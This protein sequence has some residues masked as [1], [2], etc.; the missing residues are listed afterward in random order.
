MKRPKPAASEGGHHRMNRRDFLKTGVTATAGLA[1]AAGSAGQLFSAPSRSPNLLVI[2]TDQQSA[3]TLGAYGGAVIGTPNI[4]RIGREGATLTNFF[5]NCAICTPSRGC[6]Q[7][8][9]YPHAN[10]AVHNNFAL[11]EDE[12]TLGHVMKRNG[13]DTGYIGKWHLAGKEK[14]H[15]HPNWNCWLPREYSMGY[16]DCRYMFEMWHGKMISGGTQNPRMDDLHWIGDD[17]MTKTLDLERSV[18]DENS[19]TTD[20]L[21]DRAMDFVN[22]PRENPFCLFLS[23]PDPHNPFHGRSPYREM[24]RP[25]DVQIPST[26]NQR[27]LPL[28][29]TQ[30]NKVGRHGFHFDRKDWPSG[31]HDREQ[32]LRQMK[33]QYC[34]MVKHIDDCVG[35]IL[36][37][38]EKK[39]ILDDTI[40]VFT[41]DHGDYM[42]EHGLAG[43]PCVYETVFRIP[44]LVRW[45]GHIEPGSTV[46]HCVATV[47]F[48]P[49]I[50]KLMG[51]EPSGREH[52]ND[53]SP[54]LLGGTVAWENAAHQYY[55]PYPK[56]PE[57]PPVRAG[58]FTPEY[59]LCYVFNGVKGQEHVLFDRRNDPEEID[60]LF[61]DPAHRDVVVELTQRIIRQREEVNSPELAWLEGCPR[62]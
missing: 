54:L 9:R 8:G 60:N 17:V 14:G 35:E 24:F 23:I 41:T 30:F 46:D 36:D 50:C 25:G 6:F 33:A 2:Q 22:A 12:V 49:T 15:G 26:F 57:V 16:D 51:L 48:L 19:Y 55:M 20:F 27:D 13:Y 37:T 18:G 59:H 42:G 53:A 61:H 56:T 40:V 1:V 43:K 31:I 11:H 21:C 32:Y 52:G 62:F 28:W 7:T 58:I 45:P 29:A 10:G 38:L 4:D 44:F 3:W 5:S 34:G 39:G 47:D